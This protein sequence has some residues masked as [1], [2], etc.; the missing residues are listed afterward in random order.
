VLASQQPDG[1]F[2]LSPSTSPIISTAFVLN[3]LRSRPVQE[4]DR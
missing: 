4:I 1:A 2:S 3:V